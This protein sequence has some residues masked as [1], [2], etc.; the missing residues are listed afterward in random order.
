[1]K[2]FIYLKKNLFLQYRSYAIANHNSINNRNDN[3]I[4]LIRIIHDA[5]I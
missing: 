5:N 3:N 1:M 2:R 4:L